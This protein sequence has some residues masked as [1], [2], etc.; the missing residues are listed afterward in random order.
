MT[1]VDIVH[2]GSGGYNIRILILDNLFDFVE[3]SSG[4]IEKLNEGQ[5]DWQFAILTVLWSEENQ[6]V[7]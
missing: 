7:I 5:V 2:A 4:V 1:Y 3:R 6:F